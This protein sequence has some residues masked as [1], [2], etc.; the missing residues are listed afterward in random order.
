MF[1]SMM[2]INKL[3]YPYHLF[4]QNLIKNPLNNP[5]TL[6]KRLIGYAQQAVSLTDLQTTQYCIHELTEFI[7]DYTSKYL[8]HGA[9]K[10]IEKL[11]VST[12]LNNKNVNINHNKKLFTKHL[13]FLNS[14]KKTKIF[15]QCSI[16]NTLSSNKH[17]LNNEHS[18]SHSKNTA[19]LRLNFM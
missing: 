10:T 15:L 3:E 7:D 14:E 18:L 8:T 12:S 19:L 17:N 4:F 2:D 13:M 16:L 11:F 9:S 5:L 6:V 1:F